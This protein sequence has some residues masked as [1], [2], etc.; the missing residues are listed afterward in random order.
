MSFARQV[1]I[2]ILAGSASTFNLLFLARTTRTRPIMKIICH[3]KA[4]AALPPLPQ[5]YT[6][7]LL[8]HALYKV[9]QVLLHIRIARKA[10]IELLNIVLRK[11]LKR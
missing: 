9:L 7:F 2:P 6:F 5:I 11:S 3:S 4:F 8:A 1:K 10:L